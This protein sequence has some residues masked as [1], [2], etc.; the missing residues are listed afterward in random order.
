MERVDSSSGID[1]TILRELVDSGMVK[2][3]DARTHDADE[4]L[5]VR[6]TLEGREYLQQLEERASPAPEQRLQ[7][8]FKKSWTL[9][10]VVLLGGGLVWLANVTD[11][12]KRLLPESISPET[13]E[14]AS[15][16]QIAVVN[17]YPFLTDPHA[18]DRPRFQRLTT[19]A[20]PSLKRLYGLASS[21][22]VLGATDVGVLERVINETDEYLAG[23]GS[24]AKLESHFKDLTRTLVYFIARTKGDSRFQACQRGAT[25]RSCDHI[26][27][28]YVQQELI[29]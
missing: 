15:Y 19:T 2:A 27:V 11:A 14:V 7:N 6:I 21:V 24:Q 17:L 28:A 1:L 23:K 18:S 4:Y 8:R 25:F 16:A 29:H 10:I 5:D 26:L 3:I 22:K 20:L 12:I 13:Q 9:A